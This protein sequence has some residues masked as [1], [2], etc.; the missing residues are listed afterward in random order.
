MAVK[1][2]ANVQYQ[3]IVE[4]VSRKFVPRKETCTRPVDVNLPI[5]V[6]ET[7]WM[8]GAVRKTSRAGFG[9]C[10]RNYLVIRE[11]ARS[12]QPSSAELETREIFMNAVRGR[13]YIVKDLSQ[14][15]RIIAMWREAVDGTTKTVNGVSPKGYTMNGWIMAAQFAGGKAAAEQT[16]TYDYDTFPNWDA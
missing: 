14:L 5:E 3:P 13:N 4:S 7:G 8:G 9:A 12:S 15:S 6:E 11:N 1:L 10:Q 16:Q 2:K